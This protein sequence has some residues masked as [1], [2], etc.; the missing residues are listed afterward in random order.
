MSG[1]GDW[2]K[3]AT[4]LIAFVVVLGGWWLFQQERE[5][6]LA[7]APL[8]GE[9][10]TQGLCA[11]WVIGSSSVHR[12]TS[13][14]RDLSPW[15]AHNRGIEGATFAQLGPRFASETETRAP[16]AMIL[17]AGENDIAAGGSARQAIADLEAFLAD[18][19]AKFGQTPV[20]VVSMKPSP[21]R[22]KFLAEQGRF[23]RAA[24][25]IGR[26]RADVTFVDIVP[27]LLDKGR[28]GNFYQAD[29]IHMNALGYGLWAAA[30]R[31]ALRR[32]LP[33]GVVQHCDPGR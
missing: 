22:W 9:G 10:G 32:Y 1:R 31:D 8:P 16:E 3:I 28:P 33:S 7:H 24:A 2:K 27:L 19:T 11:L 13:V 23:N 14:E 18:K 30:I 25:A 26:Q 29:G 21:T 20:F 17:Y 12:W 15:I 4:A 5:R 6:R